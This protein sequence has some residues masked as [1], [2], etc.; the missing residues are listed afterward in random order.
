MD[1]RL[2]AVVLH[3]SAGSVLAGVAL[4]EISIAPLRE[5]LFLLYCVPDL[6]KV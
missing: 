4:R 6:L 1:V 2:H 5:R 3:V